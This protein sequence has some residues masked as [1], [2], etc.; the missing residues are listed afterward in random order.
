MAHGQ[1]RTGLKGRIWEKAREHASNAI[2]GGSILVLT[3]F[4]PEHWVAELLQ[5]LHLSNARSF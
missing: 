5:S 1:G 4:T 3:G 2:I